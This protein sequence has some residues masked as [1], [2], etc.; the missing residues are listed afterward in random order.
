[1]S[2]NNISVFSGPASGVSEGN[3]R[4]IVPDTPAP[5]PEGTPTTE[6]YTVTEGLYPNVLSEYASF[7]CILTFGMLTTQELNNP[8]NTYRKVGPQRI[9]ARSGGSGSKQ[10]PTAFEKEF[11]IT[12]E[13]FIDDVEIQSVIA[14][15]SQT[16]QTN[17]NVVNFNLK[18]PYSMGVLLQTLAVTARDAYPERAANE[19]TTLSY[20]DVP[21]VLCIEFVGWNDDGSYVKIPNTKRF[22]PLRLTGIEFTVGPEGTTYQVGAVAY[23]EIALMDEVQTVY[24]DVEL[25]GETLADFLQIQ[26]EEGLPSLTSILNDRQNAEKDAGNKP[27]PDQYVIAFPKDG[28]SLSAQ[29]KAA[30]EENQA[31]TVNDNESSNSVT[32]SP[33]I[34]LEQIKQIVEDSG[35][36]NDIGLSKLSKDPFDTETKLMGRAQDSFEQTEDGTKFWFKG[37]IVVKDLLAIAFMGGM[38]IQ[39]IIEDLVLMSEYGE[40]FVTE[41]S[42]DRGLKPY[43]RIETDVYNL[44]SQENE[45]QRQR[46]AKIYVYKVVPY[47][48]SESYFN[49]P[50]STTKGIDVLRSRIPKSYDYIYTGKNDDIINF[51]LNFNTSFYAGIRYDFG[52]L[53]QDNVVDRSSGQNGGQDETASRLPQGTNDTAEPSAPVQSTANANTGER[54]GA[55]NVAQ[56]PENQIARDYTEL[57]LNSPSDLITLDLEIWG[58]PYYIADSG[59]G[60]YTAKTN[61]EQP[62]S[63][64]DESIDY[65]NDEP[66]LI[67]NFKTPID[68]NIENQSSSYGGMQFPES[69]GETVTQFSG[70]YKIHTVTN[71]ISS[72][73]FTQSLQLTRLRNQTG[74]STGDSLAEPGNT[75]NVLAELFN[76]Q[77]AN[78]GLF[79]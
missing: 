21:Y 37:G 77:A 56:S 25:R 52:Q 32:A 33:G 34:T 64:I 42:D 35:N 19:N 70:I 13:Y 11:G 36:I 78:S 47:R 10:L 6:F 72:N 60:N 29:I 4:S 71:T 9:I 48:V 45:Q 40:R 63:T 26:S 43:F 24:Q 68:Y 38:R 59:T 53:A 55:G 61:A 16:R 2:S 69:G 14:P 22:I 5:A 7:S 8:E 3:A 17:A 15:T 57:L 30:Q 62:Q 74:S 44:A 18:E 39:E 50:S 27:Q 75:D 54:G 20:V 23:N 65:Q 76:F 51:D 58:D 41:P 67:L 73:K 46:A 1:M 79:E 31:A 66:Y 28:E 49:H 12:T